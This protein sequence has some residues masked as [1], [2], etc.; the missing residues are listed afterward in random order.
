[1][2]IRVPSNH[3][4]L[5]TI[6]VKTRGDH[7]QALSAIQSACKQVAKEQLGVPTDMDTE[8]LDDTLADAL[9]EKHNMMVLIIT[10]MGIS[11]SD[12]RPRLVWHV[13]ILRQ[14]AAPTD[15]LAQGDGSLGDRCGMATFQAIPHYIVCGC[16]YR[17]PIVC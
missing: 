17:H 12:F 8:Y 11:I 6:L 9:K 10:F 4:V 15:S 2:P 16:G 7:A 13:G 3:D 5:W 1:M 14:P